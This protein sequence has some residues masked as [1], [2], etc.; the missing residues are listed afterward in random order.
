MSIDSLKIGASDTV[1]CNCNELKYLGFLF[2]LGKWLQS[3]FDVS[4][5]K[6]YAAANSVYSNCRFASEM[7]LHMLP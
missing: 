2:R 1:W 4:M 7:F 5:R 6:F 3:M